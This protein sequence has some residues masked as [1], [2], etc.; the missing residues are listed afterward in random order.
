MAA[1]DPFESRLSGTL[2]RLLDEETGPHP[3]WVDA[4]VARALAGG[5]RGAAGS[6]SSRTTMLLLAAALVIALV[7]GGALVGGRL[8]QMLPA[9]LSLLDLGPS[10]TPGPSLSSTPAPR[11]T[12][13]ATF[14]TSPP[15]GPSSTASP[16]QAAFGCAW[17][18]F[19]PSEL[20]LPP[21]PG[22][23]G[24]RLGTHS[25]YDRI[26]FDLGGTQRPSLSIEPVSP[27]FTTD[28]AG[29]PI[30]VEGSSF[31][32]IRLTGLETAAG[33]TIERD[34]R[35]DYPAIVELRNSGDF[36]A[37]QTWIVGLRSASPSCIRVTVLTQPTR[38]V[39]DVQQP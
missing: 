9:L 27:P 17:P 38:L 28:G 29:L 8:P 26:V 23:T 35:P 5:R 1:D 22:L 13:W 32:R 30:T 7:G 34:Q 20:S 19:L 15:I 31:L 33:A 39:I 16:S 25:G 6:R 14:P 4:P 18:Y 21:V 11:P 24:V 2:H 37:V 36:E 12:A 3:G 10:R